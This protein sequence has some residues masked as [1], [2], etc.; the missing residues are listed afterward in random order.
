[1]WRAVFKWKGRVQSSKSNNQGSTSDIQNVGSSD[2]AGKLRQ[3]THKTIKRVG[4]NFEALQFNTPVAALMELSNA[5]TEFDVDPDA[6]SEA[7][8][9]AVRE[10][11]GSLALMLTPFAPHAAEEIYTVVAGNDNGIVANDARFPEFNPELAKSDEIE[12]P[13]QVNG[14]LRVRILASPEIGDDELREMVMADEKVQEYVAGKEIVKIVVVPKRLV[15][16]VVK[17]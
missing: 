5:L 2:A 6:A 17:G 8:V 13:I 1:V 12:I 3:K 14:K 11:I 9:F 4:E 16:I 10:V 7:D 15:S